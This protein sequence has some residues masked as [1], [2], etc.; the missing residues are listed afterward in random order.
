MS[1]QNYNKSEVIFR[2]GECQKWMY[3]IEK[4]SVEIYANYGAENQTLLVTLDAGKYFGEI[5]LTDFVPR[6]AT[7]VAAEDD[8]QLNQI[9]EE[10]FAEYFHK[11]PAVLMSIMSNMGGR[12]RALTADYMN[13]CQ[14]IAEAA[15]SA[16]NGKEKSSGLKAKLA[17]L[18]Q[19]YIKPTFMAPS[20][21]YDVAGYMDRKRNEGDGMRT[22]R[23]NEVIFCEGDASDCMYDIQRGSVGIYVNYGKANE[24]K[25][26]ELTVE[27]FFGEMGMIDNLPRSATAVALEENT[28][29]K[30]ITAEDF[31]RYMQEKTPKVIMIMQHLAARLSKLTEDY[32]QVCR[33]ASEAQSAEQVSGDQSGWFKE[34]MKRFL[35]DYNEAMRYAG[36]HPEFMHDISSL[37]YHG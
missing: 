4:G 26:V 24:K 23:K 16:K 14:A 12:I 17:K 22:Y 29:A 21:A 1:I 7:A 27:Q 3:S 25:L 11:N 9:T 13:A 35:D 31:P 28:Q 20:A 5:G 32:M 2:E 10:N 19:D 15:D 6:T 36:D 30:I 37:Y 8:T 34:S 33:A 18:V